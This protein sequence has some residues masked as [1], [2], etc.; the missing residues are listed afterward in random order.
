MK[1]A[2]LYGQTCFIPVFAGADFSP[3]DTYG[4]YERHIYTVDMKNVQSGQEA[5]DA[6][7]YE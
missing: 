2:V 4:R 7:I 1:T 5:P 6:F 3:F